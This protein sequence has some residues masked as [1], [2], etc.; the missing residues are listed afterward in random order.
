ME[1]DRIHDP[2]PVG[3]AA[4]LR[5]RRFRPADQDA[6][7]ALVVAGLGEHWGGVDATLNP[8]LDDIASHYAKSK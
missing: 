4:G 6:V 5:I 2:S 1:A 8:D 3:E 7:K